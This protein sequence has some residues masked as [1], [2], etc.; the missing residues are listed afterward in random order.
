M[1]THYKQQAVAVQCK[2]QS[3]VQAVRHEALGGASS[4]THTATNICVFLHWYWQNGLI[5]P[6]IR[7]WGL[8]LVY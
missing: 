7:A 6:W 5:L 3:A 8:I 4:T 2:V 1:H